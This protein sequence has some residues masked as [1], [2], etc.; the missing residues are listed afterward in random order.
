MCWKR[1]V[2][3]KNKPDFAPKPQP[4][5]PLDH[6]VKSEEFSFL[7]LTVWW[8]SS[9]TT[10]TTGGAC[11]CYSLLLLLASPCSLSSSANPHTPQNASIKSVNTH[12]CTTVEVMPSSFSRPPCAKKIVIFYMPARLV[13]RSQRCERFRLTFIS[14]YLK[15]Q[16][17]KGSL[18]CCLHTD[19]FQSSVLWQVTGNPQS[20]HK[21]ILRQSKW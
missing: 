12:H 17:L 9:C 18:F 3:Y 7:H 2:M 11:V 14:V 4:P 10:P 16:S 21:T 19:C 8:F 6:G 1:N 20:S 15:M 13:C 5:P